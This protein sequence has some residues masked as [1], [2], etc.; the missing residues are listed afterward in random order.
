MNFDVFHV[1]FHW[2]AQEPYGLYVTDLVV[3]LI[4]SVSDR[5]IRFFFCQ[6]SCLYIWQYK[7]YA[8]T[9]RIV[10][11]TLSHDNKTIAFRNTYLEC[12]ILFGDR[13]YLITTSVKKTSFSL[14][15]I[16]K[17]LYSHLN[18]HSKR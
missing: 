13:N 15:I 3:L 4:F 8:C 14:F 16:H 7:T 9:Y 2:F 12:C 5:C 11:I 10:F 17:R 6:Q 18:G 1:R